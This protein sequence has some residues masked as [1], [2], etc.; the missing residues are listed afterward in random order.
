M[1]IKNRKSILLTSSITAGSPMSFNYNISNIPFH[2][3]E[4]IVRSIAL[5]DSNNGYIYYIRSTLTNNN[6]LGIAQDSN[7]V[8]SSPQT[9]FIID[10]PILG[11]HTFDIIL[12]TTGL[13]QNAIAGTDINILVEFVE[14][15]ND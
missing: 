13:V 10:R 4:M 6:V 8:I 5:N 2:P 15:R 12:S 7:N 1:K 3:H 14:F 9:T 11:L